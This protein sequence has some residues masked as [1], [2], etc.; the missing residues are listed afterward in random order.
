M[1]Q[2]NRYTAGSAIAA[3]GLLLALLQ[4]ASAGRVERDGLVEDGVA[5]A[6]AALAAAWARYS[7]PREA[8]LLDWLADGSLLVA[9]RLDGK[10]QV[11][12]VDMPL[13]S[14]GQPGL[15]AQDVTGAVAHPFDSKLVALRVLNA[16]GH[17]QLYSQRVGDAAALTLTDASA[18]DDTPLWAH[19][20]RRLAFASDRRNGRDFDVYVIETGSAAAPRLVIGGGGRWRVLDWSLDDRSLLLRQ[21]DG[22]GAA[23]LFVADVAGGSLRAIDAPAADR[24]ARA[25]IPAARFTPDGHA[26][27]YLREAGADGFVRLQLAGLDGTA[28]RDVT[29]PLEHDIEAFDVS[30]DGRYLA[31]AW[32]EG[33]FSRIAIVD[34][35]HRVELVLP[36]GLPLGI[37]NALRFDRSGMR[38]ALEAE[39]AT[40]PPDVHVIDIGAATV[41]R[42]TQSEPAVPGAAPA[43]PAQRL[44]FRTWDRSVGRPR[45]LGGY[46]YAP[47]R[48]GRHPVLVLL[49]DGPEARFR[50]G[51]DAWVQFVVN[52]LGVAVVAPNLRGSSGVGRA[53]ASLDDGLL[54]EDAIRDIGSLL[55]WIGVQPGLDASR[56]LVMGRGYGGY[57]ALAALAQ[58]GD[59][60]RSAVA[61][62]PL[63]DLLATADATPT[64]VAEFGS[65][66]DEQQ[67]VFLQRISPLGFAGS[68]LRPVLLAR[69]DG[70]GTGGLSDAEQILWRMRAN[71]RDAAY[72]A[73]DPGRCGTGCVAARAAAWAAIGSYIR[74]ALGAD[75]PGAAP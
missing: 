14:P 67:R 12:R 5:P 9:S 52:E 30:A 64:G 37:I 16:D 55:V 20:G 18:R 26:V 36:V 60:L 3:A 10:V 24:L 62:D 11:Y 39:T 42:W 57:Q 21:E 54:R 59:R 47:P 25:R 13:A 15:L 44:R 33:G 75:A 28:S 51:F 46:V 40:A 43:A 38:L 70:A 45:E 35:R 32:E 74:D 8:R 50:P 58:Y 7:L 19:D 53:F 71:R 65:S 23:R 69:F 1:Q 41:T 61:I 4:P 72:I 31:Y 63:A 68:M 73:V 6:P 22:L 17:A 29:P 49:H 27:L 56:V 48:G 66:A 2:F 34:Q